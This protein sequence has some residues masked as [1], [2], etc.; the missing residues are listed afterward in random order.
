MTTVGVGGI[1]GS[2]FEKALKMD[3]FL[4]GVTFFGGGFQAIDHFRGHP[5]TSNASHCIDIRIYGL[6]QAKF[7][8]PYTKFCNP[9]WLAIMTK[10]CAGASQVGCR[11]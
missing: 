3:V 9:Q 2:Y 5:L 4:R 1:F 8:I 11:T 7:A 6:N 10:K